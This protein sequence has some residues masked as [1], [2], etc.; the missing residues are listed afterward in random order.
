[1]KRSFF[2]IFLLISLPL[3]SQ[4]FRLNIGGTQ[5]LFSNINNRKVSFYGI[6]A[7][8]SYY[9][10]KKFGLYLGF[11]HYFPTTYYGKVKYWDQEYGTAPAN[12]TGGANDFEAGLKLKIFDP[13]SK[14][15]EINTTLSGSLLTHKGKY[16]KE[17]FLRHYEGGTF[18]PDIMNKVKSLYVGAEA[19]FKA[20]NIPVFIS[21]GYNHVP[22]QKKPFDDWRGYSVPFS[23]RI[24]FRVGISFPVMKGPVPSEIK[25]IEY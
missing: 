16:D 14:K 12:I 7:G 13:K 21:G 17:P 11:S 25:M 4:N 15:I 9:F 6:N 18:L 10:Y 8:Y 19:I 3:F 20:G 1:M 2:L 24:N 23:S 22:G 5:S